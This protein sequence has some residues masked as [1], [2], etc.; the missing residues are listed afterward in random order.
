MAVLVYGNGTKFPE[1][2]GKDFVEASVYTKTRIIDF[3]DGS[4]VKGKF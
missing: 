1:G 2:C 3:V 4:R